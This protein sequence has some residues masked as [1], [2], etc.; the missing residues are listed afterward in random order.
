[1][2]E[3]ARGKREQQSFEHNESKGCGSMEG[4]GVA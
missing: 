3:M 1:M 2:R 4:G